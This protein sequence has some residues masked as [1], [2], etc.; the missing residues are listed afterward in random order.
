MLLAI[1]TSTRWV[2]LALYDGSQ[3]LNETVWLSHD[4]HT[5]ELAPALAVLF[6]RAQVTAADLQAIGVALGPGSFT[7]LRIGLGLAKGLALARHIPMVGVP[8]L[9]IL[10]VAQ[11]VGSMPMAAVLQAGRNRLGVVWYQPSASGWQAEGDPRVLQA[12]E[13]AN[14]ITSPTLVCGELTPDQRQMLGHKRKLICLASPAQSVRRPGFLA[15][16]AWKRYQAGK[17]DDPVALSPIYLHIA[18]GIPA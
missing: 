18:E 15:E 3:V 10:A 5:V 6:D 17:T 9:D 2:G 1:D 7:S 8:T 4:H 13:L 16:I 14:Q 12:E 11:P